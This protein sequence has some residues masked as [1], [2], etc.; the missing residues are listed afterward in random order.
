MNK[1]T[2]RFNE[3]I[4]TA[5]EQAGYRYGKDGLV[6]Y[7]Q[8]HTLTFLYSFLLLKSFSTLC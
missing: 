8:Y 4:L 1:T 3:A 2:K 6:S 7:L 5:A